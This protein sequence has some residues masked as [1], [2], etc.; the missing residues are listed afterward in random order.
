MA[1]FNIFSQFDVSEKF[2]FFQFLIVFFFLIRVLRFS[3]KGY[4][5]FSLKKVLNIV[6]RGLKFPIVIRVLVLIFFNIVVF[7][8]LRL[9]PWGF[10]SGRQIW[11]RFWAGLFLFF[12]IVFYFFSVG[13]VNG[14]IHFVPT[15]VPNF[16]GFLL[17]WVE[18][19]SFFFRLFTL[20]LRL[21]ANMMAGHVMVSV[22]GG[23]VSGFLVLLDWNFFLPCLVFGV[24][25][26]LFELMVC[27]VQSFVFVILLY[28]YY[29]EA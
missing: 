7:N 28:N 25:L 5:Y 10:C 15:G 26:W 8:L 29:L 27:F 9:F 22:V 19:F 23:L 16:F 21:C 3:G 2:S 11:F 24:V 18:L 12:I 20:V 4:I 13:G 14:F 1:F 17:F 6:S